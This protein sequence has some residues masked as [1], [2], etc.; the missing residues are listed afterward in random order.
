[1]AGGGCDACTCGG[2]GG[3]ARPGSWLGWF[4]GAITVSTSASDNQRYEG[5]KGSCEIGKRGR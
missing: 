5:Q 2:L 1:M 4:V 3:C